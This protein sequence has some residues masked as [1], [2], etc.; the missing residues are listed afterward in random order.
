ML[1]KE[2]VIAQHP[3]NTY[4]F[5]SRYIMDFIIRH[6]EPAQQKAKTELV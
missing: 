6:V 4:T 5:H 2:N 1:L 3:D